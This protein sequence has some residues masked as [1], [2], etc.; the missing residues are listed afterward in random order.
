MFVT[1]LH[2]HTSIEIFQHKHYGNE[3]IPSLLFAELV[4]FHHVLFNEGGC[5]GGSQEEA[6]ELGDF[7]QGDGLLRMSNTVSENIKNTIIIL[8]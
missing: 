8:R 7:A 2:A 3:Q 6:G 4:H 1:W 5:W